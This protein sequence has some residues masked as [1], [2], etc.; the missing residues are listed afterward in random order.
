MKQFFPYGK[1][2][3]GEELIN[4]EEII[5]RIL[6]DI[7]G[8]QSVILASPRRYG[9][10]SIILEIL[11]RIKS[12][13][14]MT[15]FVDLFEKTSIREFAEAIV[16]AVLENETKKARKVMKGIKTNLQAFLKKAEFR[17]IW[18]EHEFIL[19][20]GSTESKGEALLDEA[21]DFTQKFALA[22]KGKMIFAI[23]EFGEIKFW[24]SN[25]LK[26]MRSKFQRHDRV[27]YIFSGSQESL[28]KDLFSN[29][30]Q[31]FY[32]FGKIV[33]LGSLPEKDLIPYLKDRYSKANFQ[34]SD[35]VAQEIG[36]LTQN[37]PHYFKVLAQAVLDIATEKTILNLKDVK[38]GFEKSFLQVKAELDTEWEALRRARLQRSVLKFLASSDTGIYSKKGLIGVDKAKIYF[39]LSELERK[40]IIRK[41]EKGKYQFTNPFFKEY[42]KRM[43][44]GKLI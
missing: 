42:I 31:A 21:L 11:S 3:T 32:G 28:M 37:H 43:L 7:M 9:K 4:R 16:T 33:G 36:N 20:F 24:D 23:D 18:K 2:V 35:E 40:G 22:K 30:S 39:S 25:L 8:G 29:K 19:S 5:D 15:G 6:N 10:S 44:E 1:P 27:T 13:G 12:K 14:I 41:T 34:I 17:Y 26:K 38:A